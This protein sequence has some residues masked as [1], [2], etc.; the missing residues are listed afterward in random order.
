MT[1]EYQLFHN[2]RHEITDLKT[3]NTA[4]PTPVDSQLRELPSCEYNAAAAA[5][6]APPV[7]RPVGCG[8]RVVTS[9]LAT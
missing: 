9:F 8:L 2:M 7:L 4:L 6:V 3:A 1:F 5:A